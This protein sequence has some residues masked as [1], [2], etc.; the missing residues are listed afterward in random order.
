MGSKFVQCRKNP[1][2]VKRALKKISHTRPVR[3]ALAL[4]QPD[5]RIAAFEASS[6]GL[7]AVAAERGPDGSVADAIVLAVNE[8]AAEYIGCPVDRILDQRLLTVMPNLR[9]NGTW[10][11]CL[12]VLERQEVERFRMQCDFNGL[13]TWFHVTATP[14]RDGFLLN[15]R[16]ISYVQYSVFEAD[17]LRFEAERA[18]Q[19]LTA[20]LTARDLL[21]NE[22]RQAAVTDSLTGA[23]NRRG[24]DEV[25]RQ[26][27]ATAHRH[28][29]PLSAVA[30]DLDH[31]KEVND[32]F[33]HAAG[34]M[35]LRAAASLVMQE[36]RLDT[37]FLG[38]VGGEEFMLLCPQTTAEGAAALAERIRSRIRR[39]TFMINGAE[40]RLTA[41]FGVS[42]LGAKGDPSHMLVAADQALYQAKRLGRDRIIVSP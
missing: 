19:N 26:E 38:R 8:R 10:Q 3:H 34:D 13:D 4:Q 7:L 35:V 20:E 5:I 40:V 27:A 12:K 9:G 28:R 1:G 36:L 42:Q 39:E 17:V 2:R 21:E 18:L 14:L 29:H 33:G 15:F 31:F 22:L 24:F 6:D 37:D 32:R 11:R 16:D 23:L 30:M 25:L 41:S